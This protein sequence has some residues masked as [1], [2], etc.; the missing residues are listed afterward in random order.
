MSRITD[1]WGWN[2]PR[3]S[4]AVSP[5]QRTFGYVLVADANPTRASL[6]LDSISAFGVDTRVVHDAR[7]ALDHLRQKGAPALLIID[8]S[9]PGNDGF[10]VIDA[11]RDSGPQIIAWAAVPELREYAAHR[12]SGLNVRILSGTAAPEV[13]RGA[14]ER[15]IRRGTA[16][17]DAAVGSDGHDTE[18][19]SE[20]IRALA[21]AARTLSGASGVAVY[22]RTAGAMRFRA[23][24]TWT[25]DT[26]LPHSPYHLPRVFDWILETGEALV[27]PDLTGHQLA[28]V[29]TTSV[30]DV[31]RGLV[32]V[33][34]VG[35]DNQIIGTICVFD[36]QPLTFGADVIDALKALGREGLK[37]PSAPH[38]GEPAA[39]HEPPA[40]AGLPRSDE[41][42][43]RTP[44][45]PFAAPLDRRDAALIIGHEL[46]RLRREQRPLSVVAFA[47]DE[48]RSD[49]RWGGDAVHTVGETLT[50]GIRASDIAVRWTPDELLLVLP[51][52]AAVEA[53]PVAERVRAAMHASV[54]R[55]VAVSGG[56]VELLPD[57]SFESAVARATEQV[58]VARQRGHNRVA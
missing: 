17:G 56:V 19:V 57:E 43:A 49:A 23:S 50:R 35:P 12:L 54:G 24:V 16:A 48:A 4:A 39:T 7:E 3:N 32:A 18:G 9:L 29:S 42:G 5:P 21:E 47:V 10:A 45:D 41:D 25:S 6:C 38:A 51:G 13:V 53:R 36:L 11:V 44:E 28:E 2:G 27:V 34:I 30:Q 15:A 40:P 14:I 1:M 22:W 52:L 33:P 37:R 58:Q 31:V 20:V 8:L 26:P 55:R 46:S